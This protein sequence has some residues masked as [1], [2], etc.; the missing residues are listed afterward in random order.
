[1]HN[2]PRRGETFVTRKITRGIANILAGKQKKIYLGNLDAKRDWGFSPEYVEMMWLMLQQDSAD[3]FVVGTGE[4]HT[5]KDFVEKAFSYAGIEIEWKGRDLKE[6]GVVRSADDKCQNK[7]KPG[8]VI[9]EIDP[10]YFR[11]TEVNHLRA[12]ISKAKKILGWRPRVTFDELVKI[13]VD[14]D[15]KL[16]GINSPGEGIAISKKKG[17]L[18][19]NHDFSFYEKIRE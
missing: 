4:S 15:L 17:F 18:Y 10:K 8:D 16:L 6:K 9:M 14:Y 19:T 1:M 12:D 13:M 11:P 5:V 7:I 3:D 2:S